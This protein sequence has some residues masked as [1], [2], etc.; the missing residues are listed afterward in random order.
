M[1]IPEGLRIVEDRI[2]SACTRCG[3]DRNSVKLI[4]VSKTKPVED[5]LE[6]YH[7]GYEVFGENKVQELCDKAGKIN[8]PI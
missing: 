3:R 7:A 5:I 2:A 4:A 1:N 6:V 8:E